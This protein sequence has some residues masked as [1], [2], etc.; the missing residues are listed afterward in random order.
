MMGT[1]S[2]TIQWSDD[3][4]WVLAMKQVFWSCSSS[5]QL[6]LF[7][8]FVEGLHCSQSANGAS[9]SCSSGNCSQFGML[10]SSTFTMLNST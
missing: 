9:V 4:K 3:L 5:S 10:I 6:C 7:V 1:A 2:L 8:S